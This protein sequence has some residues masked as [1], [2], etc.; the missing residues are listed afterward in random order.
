M[1]ELETAARAATSMVQAADRLEAA[2]YLPVHDPAQRRQRR[3]G[4]VRHRF[5]RAGKGRSVAVI[6]KA[7]A[8]LG[9]RL[10]EAHE[11]RLA[12]A[13]ELGRGG[14]HRLAHERLAVEIAAARFGPEG[15]LAIGAERMAAGKAVASERF[16]D[17]Q[18]NGLHSSSSTMRRPWRADMH[19]AA[20]SATR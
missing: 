7:L 11:L 5:E 9:G 18:G 20:Y 12:E 3:A 1:E 19:R 2:A 14:R 16:T 6:E 13:L 8:A 17:I 15:L 4:N 10:H